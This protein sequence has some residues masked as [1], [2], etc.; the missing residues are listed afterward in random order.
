MDVATAAAETVKFL[1][2]C[3]PSVTLQKFKGLSLLDYACD[4]E[5]F[6]DKNIHAA[7][8]V[9]EVIYDAH[10][11]AIE[12]ERIVSNIQNYHQQVQAFLNDQLVYV[13]Q[14]KDLTLMTTIDENGRLP[15]HIALK[16][17]DRLG[18]IKLLVKGNPTA[19]QSADNNG[20]LPL[21]I[22]CMHHDSANVIQ[23]L[24]ELDPSALNAVDRD[25][26]T[27]LHLL[28]HG[29]K[30]EAIALLLDEFD[31]AS[32][33]TRNAAKQLPIDLLWESTEV[34]AEDRE[35]IEYTESMY[36]LLRA[37]PEMMMGIDV[38]TMQASASASVSTLPCQAGKKRKFGNWYITL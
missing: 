32:V 9:I 38:Q 16:N 29:A 2:D 30:Y 13:R 33:S 20:V 21:H 36:R 34:E 27:A 31:A 37:N 18:S 19:V 23:Y 26:N 24:A 6:N 12:D 17:N 14:A 11:E 22:A 3:D 8:A 5:I 7:L 28:C 1:L 10:P 15:L 25:G 4:S 35:S